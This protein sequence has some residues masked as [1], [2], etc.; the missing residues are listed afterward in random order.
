MELEFF[1]NP[2]TES[3]KLKYNPKI[4]CK[5]ADGITRVIELSEL[6]VHSWHLHWISEMLRWLI[7][8]LK[9]KP[10][11]LRL[12]QHSK[13]ELSH[14]SSATF[15]IEY[16]F[17]F[18]NFQE[19]KE[20]CGVANRTNYDITQHAKA[21]KKNLKFKCPKTKK[22][23][24]PHVIE[25]SIGLDRLFMAI[26]SD[27]YEYSSERD[28]EILHLPE[29]LCPVQYAVFPLPNKTHPKEKYHEKARMLF[30]GLIK[31]GYRVEYDATGSIGRRYAR[32]DT[33]GT[34]WCLTVD[35][36][37]LVDDTV[38]V[39][40]RDTKKQYRVGVSDLI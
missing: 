40:D 5:F 36:Q 26:L 30:D 23:L 38:T 6:S 15:D 8:V 2:D 24:Y 34:K 10:E 4:T 25:P 37:T 33:K 28:Y 32:Q 12:R 9:L 29:L 31:K 11:N 22:K 27:S 7:T 1:F 39:R 16:K 17:P 21:S 3:P 18:G 13:D 14:Y 19:F 20:L 35:S